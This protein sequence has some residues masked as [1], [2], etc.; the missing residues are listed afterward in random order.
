MANNLVKWSDVV[1]FWT[2]AFPFV[3]LWCMG[4]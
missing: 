1:N 4:A 3:V 2:K